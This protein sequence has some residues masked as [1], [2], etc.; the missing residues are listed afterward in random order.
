M[1]PRPS[2]LVL[3]NLLLA[4][5]IA[6]AGWPS[7][8][9]ALHRVP[10]EASASA[11]REGHLPGPVEVES[12]LAHLAE[13]GETSPAAHEDAAFTLLLETT[14]RN[15]DGVQRRVQLDKAVA[16]FREYLSNVPGDA[17]AWAGLTDAFIADGRRLDAMHALKMSMI[18]APRSPSLL[19]WRCKAGLDLFYILDTEGRDLL[20]Q[21]FRS[22]MEKSP[23]AVVDLAVE[24]DAVP[25]VRSLL[26]DSPGALA[27]FDERLAL[28]RS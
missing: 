1:T 4:V 23:A 9:A 12:L 6:A 8:L 5:G 13:A 2:P 3:G 26:Q 7:A 15:G 25:I 28:S 18:V 21:Q 27:T 14:R 19:L 24:H 20:E 10:V 17:L 22:A 11:V 16:E